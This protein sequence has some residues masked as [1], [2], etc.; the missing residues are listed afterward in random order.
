LFTDFT[1][2]VVRQDITFYGKYN[3]RSYDG[4]GASAV[5]TTLIPVITRGKT[6]T[7]ANLTT[8]SIARSDQSNMKITGYRNVFYGVTVQLNALASYYGKADSM[9]NSNE[10]DKFMENNVC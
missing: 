4:T 7:K 1:E 9:L 8:L 6:K 10:L 5:K 3:T 2:Q